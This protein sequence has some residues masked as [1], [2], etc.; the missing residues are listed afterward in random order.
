VSL[1]AVDGDRL[2][3]LQRAETGRGANW[4]RFA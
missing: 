2:D 4:V 1:Y 3:L